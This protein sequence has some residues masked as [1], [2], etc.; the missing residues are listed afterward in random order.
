VFDVRVLWRR[1]WADPE[2][3]AGDR[4]AVLVEA[5]FVFP[6]VIFVALAVMEFGFLMAAQS[7]AQSA[8]RDGV[9]FGAANF[10]VAGSNQAAAD[11]IAA[12]VASDLSART[13]YDTPLKLYVYKADANGAPTGGFASCTTDCYRYTWN[14]SAFVFD[15]ASQPWTLPQACIDPTSGTNALDSI[16]AYVEMRHDYI[17]GAFGSS[18]TLKEYTVSRLEPKPSSQC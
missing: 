12:T 7:T 5:A 16:G 17:T 10:A 13:S 2:R 8:T 18:N 11:Q 6:V 1:T 4:G 9:R 3:G 14:G 15:A